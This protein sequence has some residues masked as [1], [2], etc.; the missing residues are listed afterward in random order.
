MITAKIYGKLTAIGEIFPLTGSSRKAQKIRI[1]TIPQ[2]DSLGRI[3]EKVNFYDVFIYGQDEI[4]NTWEGYKKEYPAPMVT[5]EVYLIGRL[6]YDQGQR[7]YNNITLRL[8]KLI[9]HYE[10]HH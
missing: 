1:E 6:K 10:T 4:F 8:K 5:A 9:Y 7:P 2:P 3:N